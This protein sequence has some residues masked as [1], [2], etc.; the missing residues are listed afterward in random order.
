MRIK[1]KSR[2]LEIIYVLYGEKDEK[3]NT[4]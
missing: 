1:G 3:N 4:C 2:C